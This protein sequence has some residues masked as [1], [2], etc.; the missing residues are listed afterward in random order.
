MGFIPEDHI[1]GKAAF[2]LYS[3]ATSS[4]KFLRIK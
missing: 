4:R 2:V 1:I 3:S